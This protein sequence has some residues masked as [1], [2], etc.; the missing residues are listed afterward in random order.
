MITTPRV[1]RRQRT[2]PLLGLPSF[3][4]LA[5]LPPSA[6]IPLAAVLGGLR[7]VAAGEGP[8]SWKKR[9][10]PMAAYWMAVAAHSG[11]AVRSITGRCTVAR[12][13]LSDRSDRKQRNPVLALAE[14]RR[15]VAI[16]PLEKLRLQVALGRIR[17][18]CAALA[19]D[20]WP[21]VPDE[22]AYWRAVSVW[23]GHLA[24]AVAAV[25]AADQC[26][27]P[28]LAGVEERADY[29]TLPL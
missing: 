4:I 6:L 23:A 13:R 16:P 29:A 17:A 7:D 1:R 2:S 20:D 27:L 3:Q 10:A 18:E 28:H 14:C 22:A 24:R 12:P 15:L 21:A 19:D 25:T 9:N 5:A 26:D 8:R 11:A